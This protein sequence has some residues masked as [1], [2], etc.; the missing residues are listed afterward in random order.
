MLCLLFPVLALT[1]SAACRM[2][3]KKR[4]FCARTSSPESLQWWPTFSAVLD[5]EHG[6]TQR[7][8]G[9]L[10]FSRKCCYLQMLER[11]K[12]DNRN[13]LGF[14]PTTSL[15]MDK[16]CAEDTTSFVFW[17]KMT[18]KH[19][20]TEYYS[21]CTLFCPTPTWRPSVQ[22]FRMAILLIQMKASSFSSE[23]SLENGTYNAN[24]AIIYSYD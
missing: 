9:V 23:H 7:P 3:G 5:P 17:I 11:N 13:E 19:F 24:L 2:T 20:C 22:F 1:F 21:V 18:R 8:S 10:Y 6:K 14:F 15:D 16:N 4:E 12:M